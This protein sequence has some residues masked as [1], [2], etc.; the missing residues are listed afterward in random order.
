MPTLEFAKQYKPLF[1]TKARYIDLW[2]GRGRGGSFTGT[3]YALHLLTCPDY[4]RGYFMREIFSDIRESLWRDFKDR[5]AENET[6]QETDFDIN[7][8]QMTVRYKP[9]GN[10]I[11]SKGF[12][13]SSSNR[14]SKLKSIA[15][16]THVFIEE[17]DEISEGDFNQLDD[18]LRTVKGN[19]QVVR[20]FNP[21]PKSHWVWK[22]NYTLKDHPAYQGYYT[23]IPKNDPALLSIHSTYRDNLANLN[24][25]FI[26]KL[27]NYRSTDPDYF[28][29]M[30]EGLISEGAKGRIYRNW[31]TI[32]GMP[33]NYEKFYGLDFGFSNDPVALVECENHNKTV[34]CEEKIYE[35]GMLNSELS[36]RMR[37]LGIKKSSKIYAD[38]AEPKDIED[39]KRMGW[40]VIKCDK[41]P[42]KSGIQFVKE[43]QIV[44]TESSKNLWHENKNYKWALDQAKN[45]TNDPRDEYNH[46]MDAI[47]YA[48]VT[49][50][51]KPKGIRII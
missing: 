29:L 35:S 26:T 18:S 15:G 24:R 19:I 17:F 36:A 37:S 43:Y 27:L 44:A 11:I 45:P 7:E 9:T 22:R 31:Q 33:H 39:M 5:I 40:N 23:A 42:V 50:F 13:K 25:S 51:R 21:P 38:A 6:L 4:F 12:K 20:I 14:I 32:E 1:N 28:Y 41:G 16:A 30:V 46:L 48:V 49:K 8:N 2:G 3:Q 10:Y 47:R 34:W